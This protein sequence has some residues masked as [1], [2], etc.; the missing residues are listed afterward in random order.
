MYLSIKMQHEIPWFMP[1]MRV[2]LK[3]RNILQKEI[4]GMKMALS[5]GWKH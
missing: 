5:Y 1:N 3:K 2:E 4:L